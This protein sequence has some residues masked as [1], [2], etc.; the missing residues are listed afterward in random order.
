[1]IDHFKHDN[2]R[3]RQADRRGEWYTVVPG[4]DEQVE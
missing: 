3:G 2:E 1:M 4:G